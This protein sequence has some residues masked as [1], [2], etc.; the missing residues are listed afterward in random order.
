M[1][2][3]RMKG[4]G[5]VHDDD[6]LGIRILGDGGIEHG[7]EAPLSRQAKADRRVAA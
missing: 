2:A 6:N 5:R 3:A 7:G 4:R 1:P